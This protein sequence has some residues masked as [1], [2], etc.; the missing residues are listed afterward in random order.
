VE[1]KLRIV[2]NHGNCTILNKIFSVAS[3]QT[4]LSKLLCR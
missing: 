1:H 3:K 2:Q 4:A